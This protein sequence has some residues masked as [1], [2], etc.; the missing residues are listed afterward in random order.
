MDPEDLIF[1]QQQEKMKEQ[2]TV[3]NLRMKGSLS[4]QVHLL[5]QISQPSPNVKVSAVFPSYFGKE[6]QKTLLD[7]GFVQGQPERVLVAI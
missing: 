6:A 1:M 4:S 5:S 3:S 7:M 2:A